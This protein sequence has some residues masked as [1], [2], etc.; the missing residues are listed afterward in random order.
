MGPRRR[1]HVR[2]H[3]IVSARHWSFHPLPEPSRCGFLTRGGVTPT[4]P[5]Q[6]PDAQV[7]AD[8][9]CTTRP[10]AGGVYE[11]LYVRLNRD[12]GFDDGK[13]YFDGSGDMH[14]LAINTPT[15]ED[16][17]IA[18]EVQLWID[19]VSDVIGGPIVAGWV[20]AVEYSDPDPLPESFTV[21]FYD[22]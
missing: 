12:F 13:T 7:F 16:P 15:S 1:L 21:D 10:V 14:T 11:T 9:A 20:I 8:E 2:R 6:T 18:Y 3:C 17:D 22:E 4:P 5:V 19:Y